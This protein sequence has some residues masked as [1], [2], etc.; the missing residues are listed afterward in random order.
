MH[1]HRVQLKTSTNFTGNKVHVT[2]YC[3]THTHVEDKLSSVSSTGKVVFSQTQT[4]KQR[5]LPAW[6]GREEPA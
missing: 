1:V 4:M 6:M 2:I 5:V 3:E